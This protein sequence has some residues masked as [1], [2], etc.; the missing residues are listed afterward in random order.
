MM[1]GTIALLGFGSIAL[2]AI[3]CPDSFDVDGKTFPCRAP[4][5]CVEGYVCHPTRYV[6]VLAGSVPDGGALS[7]DGSIGSSTH[8]LGDR[9]NPVGTCDE[10]ICVDGYCCENSCTDDCHR[11][12]VDPGHC[13]PVQ[14]GTDPDSNC[15]NRTYQCSMYTAARNVLSCFALA[16]QQVT[17]GT[18]G[19][20]GACRPEACTNGVGL[21]ISKCANMGCLRD[22]ACPAGAPVVDWDS[23]AELCVTGVGAVCS[24]M[25][26]GTGCCSLLGACC[27]DA[28][29][30][31]GP[32]CE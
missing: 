13:T 18:C 1:R 19:P 16:D 17:G 9:Y 6:C 20:T 21:E 15:G 25:A 23:P 7:T 5:D 28:M 29:C 11:C 31:P 24:L 27:P 22:G 32:A 14:D 12:D 10:G 8:N 2:F 26:G 3:A 30:T 4:G